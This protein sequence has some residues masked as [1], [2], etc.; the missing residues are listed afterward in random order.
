[1]NCADALKACMFTQQIINFWQHKGNAN[2]AT[3]EERKQSKQNDDP[4]TTPCLTNLLPIYL[5][6]FACSLP[7][8]LSLPGATSLPLHL[9]PLLSV[10]QNFA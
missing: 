9:R 1:M 6:R 3:S 7:L 8:F 2:W 4:D 10:T 5:C